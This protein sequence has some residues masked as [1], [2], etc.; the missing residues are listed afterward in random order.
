MVDLSTS[1]QHS[2]SRPRPAGMCCNRCIYVLRL[3]PSFVAP[4]TPPR[5]PTQERDEGD[6]NAD[7]SASVTFTI[8]IPANLAADTDISV[9]VTPRSSRISR[10]RTLPQIAPLRFQPAAS[11]SPR[12]ATPIAPLRF[13][14]AASGPRFPATP[15]PSPSPVRQRT[16]QRE[17]V[18]RLLIH[19]PDLSLF[20][21]TMNTDT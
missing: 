15:S 9:V 1:H 2:M 18:V 11:A 12:P 16:H 17:P 13:Q 21:N 6:E 8:N 20:L 5:S 19:V 10:A 14:P 4:H 3:E 7:G